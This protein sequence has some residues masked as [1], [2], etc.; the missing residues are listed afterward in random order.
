M[1]TTRARGRCGATAR[2]AALILWLLLPPV[3]HAGAQTPDESAQA[4]LYA[5]VVPSLRDAIRGATADELN[6]YRVDATFTAASGNDLATIDGTLDLRYVNQTGGSLDVLPFRLYPNA[7][8]YDTG[9]MAIDS[10][11]VGGDALDVELSVA[12][13]VASVVLPR[14]L[15]PGDAVDLTIAFATTIPTDPTGSYGMFSLDERTGTY[16]LAH[17]LPLLAGFDPESGFVLDPPSRNGDPVFTNTA[18]FDVRLTAPSSLTFVTT[19][20]EVD[21]ASVDRTTT[22][23]RFVSG[24]VRDF[25]MVADA[26][27]DETSTQVGETTVRSW[28]N[29][30]SRDGGAAVLA[31]GAKSLEVYERLFGRYPYAELDLAQV[32]LGNGAG[33]VE[34]PQLAFIGSAYYA[35]TEATQATPGLQE[36]VVAHEVAH[37]WW[38]GLVGNDQYQHAFMDE[39]LASYVTTVYFGAVYGAAAEEEQVDYNLKAA[40]FSEL[41]ND[42]DQIVDQP[43]DDFPS[44]RSYGATVYAKGALAFGAIRAAIGDDAFFAALRA[45]ASEYEFAVATPADLKGAFEDASGQNLDELWRHW[46]DAAEGRDDYDA[47]DLANLLRAIGR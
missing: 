11:V 35:P 10:A 8:E 6:R 13:T 39:G 3:A 17:W 7:D 46:F 32:S 41:F 25:V 28:F 30:N 38:Y 33:G 1:P 23:H 4:D 37:Q 31:A 18:L 12:D 40:Y 19:G 20:S 44:A 5:A 45:Y 26:D 2:A 34:F 15:A 21:S 16:A 24:P 43:T 9:G 22:R 29:P 47:A 27:Y 14:T 42:R 36:F